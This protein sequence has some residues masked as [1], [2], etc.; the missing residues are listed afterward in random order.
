MSDGVSAA[1]FHQGHFFA[2]VGRAGNI[3]FDGA[4]QLTHIAPDQSLIGTLDRMGFELS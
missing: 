4:A 1:K 3:A 2:V